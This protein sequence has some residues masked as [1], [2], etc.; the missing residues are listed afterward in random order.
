MVRK[1]VIY[2]HPVLRQKGARIGT[3][4]PEIRALA[5]DMIETMYD[6]DGVGLAA[7]QIGEALQIAVVDVSQAA[8]PG[9]YLRVNGED[10]KLEEIMPL[11][12]LNPVV[13]PAGER[14]S[15][16]EGCLSFPDIRGEISRPGAVR[17][18]VTTLEGETWVIETD[19]LFARAIQHE[20][21][22]LNGILFI[23]RMS[24]AR[25][26]ALR[27]TLKLLQLEGGRG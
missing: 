25:K 1:I 11:V 7:Q 12:F 26:V 17:A 21:D 10:R 9:T 19:G 15:E 18:T 8:E 6:A 20:V 24:S 27:K 4:T 3:V 22:H 16:T 5:Q 23:D 13:V 14:E 2:G